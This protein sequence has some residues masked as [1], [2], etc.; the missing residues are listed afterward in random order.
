MS[1]FEIVRIALTCMAWGTWAAI[2]IRCWECRRDI[3]S[4]WRPSEEG[5]FPEQHGP[6]GLPPKGH[7]PSDDEED[8][9]DGEHSHTERRLGLVLLAP[10]AATVEIIRWMLWRFSKEGRREIELRQA[11]RQQHLADT[12]DHL[13]EDE[14]DD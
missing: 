3:P 2:G 9:E 14:S 1:T 13:I 6:R 11:R 4:G 5:L 7:I 12:Y 10:V 8:D